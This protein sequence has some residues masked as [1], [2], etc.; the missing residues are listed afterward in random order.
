[1]DSIRFPAD[2]EG[3]AILGSEYCSGYIDV[4]GQW[5]TGFYCPTSGENTNVFCCGTETH[6]YCCTKK[7]QMV[8]EEME[9]VTVIIGFLVGASSA[10]ILLT[11][12]SCI[13]CP[14]CPN[15]RRKHVEKNEGSTYRQASHVINTGSSGGANHSTT[16]MLSY[17]GGEFYRQGLPHNHTLPHSHTL[18]HTLAHQHSFRGCDGE[19]KYGTLGREPRN[20]PTYHLLPRSS[21]ILIP[22]DTPDLLSE[23]R[24][25]SNSGVHP[26]TQ[27]MMKVNM[28]ERGDK[29]HQDGEEDNDIY[30]S[31]KF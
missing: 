15:Y 7:D 13:C 16:P 23:T 30:Q 21:Y 24:M 26:L 17:L 5:N 19:R 1:M 12:I 29:Q 2:G 3:G 14:W 9:G 31:T 6:K 22:Q 18:P 25:Q 27:S 11:I 8:K 4:V 10:I 20:L 28:V